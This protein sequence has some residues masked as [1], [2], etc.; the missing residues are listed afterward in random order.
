VG[1]TDIDTLRGSY[2]ALNEGDVDGALEALDAEAV[3]YESPELPGGDEFHGREALRR[4]LQDFL[5]EWRQFHQEIEDV[6]VAGDRVAVLIHLKAVGR[7]SG[8]E[9]DTRY[10]HVWTMRNGKGITV[11]GYRDQEAARRS[12]AAP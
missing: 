12:L 11:E 2:A 5:A 10:A 9:A 8:I 4:F 1:E 3:W 6:V 7:I